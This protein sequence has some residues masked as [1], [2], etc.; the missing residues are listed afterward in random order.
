VRNMKMGNNPCVPEEFSSW[1]CDQVLIFLLFG[2][3]FSLQ[4]L[5][6]ML[7]IRKTND[8]IVFGIDNL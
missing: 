2:F 3:P 1:A 6:K 7:D 4:S 8:S 5:C